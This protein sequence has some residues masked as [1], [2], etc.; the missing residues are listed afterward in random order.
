MKKT[1]LSLSILS[2]TLVFSQISEGGF[3][4][5][6]K[7]VLDGH[8]VKTTI[9]YEVKSIQKPDL[10]Q[11]IAADYDASVKGEM[12]RIG[13]LKPVSITFSNSGTWKTL[14]NGDKVWRL[15]I[16]IPD[17]MA[18][19]LYFSQDVQIPKGGKLFAYNKNN[20]QY[21]GAYTSNTPAFRAMEMI[22]GELLTLEYLMPKGSSQFPIIEINNVG[23]YYRGVEDRIAAFR[24]GK[25][26]YQNK[27]DACQVDVA[28]SEVSGWEGQRDAVVQYTIVNN[29]SI[30]SC[31][32][33]VINNTANDCKPYILTANHCGEPTTSSELTNDVFYFNYQRPTCSSGVTTQY[34][35]ARSQTMSGASLK[36]SS[37]LGTA[38]SS[39]SIGGAIKGSDFALFEL[40][41][42]IP[43]SYN[44]YYAGWNR[45]TSAATS[46]VGIHHPAGH[47]KKIS[48]YSN[49]LSTTT[50]NG[51]G[52]AD[53][54]W[55]V[56]W[57]S[58]TNGHGVTEGG[59]SG[60]PLF[61]QNG[62]I[63]GHL[64]GGSSFCTQTNAP[65]SYG[66]LDKAWQGEGNNNNQ[67]LRPWL[68]PTNSGV[69]SLNG[70]Y[71][72]CST[73]GGGSGPCT[74]SATYT[75]NQGVF[76]GCDEYIE[77]VSLNTINRTSGCNSYS[78]FT[79]TS[80]NLARGQNYT[81]TVTPF[82]NGQSGSAYTND[83]IAAWIDW[84]NDGDYTDAGERIAYVIV[85]AGWSSVFNFTVPNN[86]TLGNLKMRVRISYQP[87]D[88]NISPC[89]ETVWGE[90][91][92]YT[93]NITA[94]TG[95]T[96]DVLNSINIYPNPTNHSFS[97]DLEGLENQVNSIEV[98]DL[99]GRIVK[100][101]TEVN[102]NPIVNLF[103]EPSGIYLVKLNSSLGIVTYKVIKN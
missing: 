43:S 60:S 40:N 58:T 101:I 47:E 2:S 55:R 12:Y 71:D 13:V 59:S 8:K 38:P 35:G 94:T 6:F 66:K 50:Y 88:G 95:V 5:T 81:L 89:G 73:S 86:A 7:K 87:V 9:D 64:S 72:P 57:T 93:V 21:V 62:L 70:S 65:D 15:G 103:K 46:G 25:P 61:N 14:P 53:A 18:L 31:T 24:D 54:H 83:E 29:G 52:W 11:I 82:A 100:R 36:A 79:S 68:D 19:N 80:T 20:S 23:Y 17:A 37:E 10:T 49:Q 96:E 85:A 77:N 27:A 39:S 44:P 22:E 99:T 3:P 74:A 91:E 75:D 32:G 30:G 78:N 97:L 33:S 51:S 67:R 56:F 102:A 45:A 4:S 69:L 84:N 90:V 1:L 76:Q 98:T 41:S 28:C 92:D 63:V 42:A 34:N 16:E 48:T 26:A